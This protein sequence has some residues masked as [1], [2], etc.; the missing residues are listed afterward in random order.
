MNISLITRRLYK[1]DIQLPIVLFFGCWYTYLWKNIYILHIYLY[2]Y[3][4]LSAKVY[5][6]ISMEHIY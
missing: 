2:I 1:K 6:N 5:I 4:N 3:I